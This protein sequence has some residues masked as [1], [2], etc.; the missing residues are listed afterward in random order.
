ME[1]SPEA[2]RIGRKIS[3]I[4]REKD[5]SRTELAERIGRLTGE[6]KPGPMWIARRVKGQIHLTDVKVLDRYD[7]DKVIARFEPNAELTLI[8]EA[9]GVDAAELAAAASETDQI[10]TTPATV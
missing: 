5:I 2:A 1:R 6:E 9:L 10:E 3:R 4:M 7:G 8:A